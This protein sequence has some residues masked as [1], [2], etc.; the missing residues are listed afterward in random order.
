MN[1]TEIWIG[2][3]IPL[4]VGPLFIYLKSLYDN[5]SKNNRDNKLLVYENQY[6]KLSN[7]LT[8]FY[9]PVYIKLLCIYQ[10]NYNV[11]I[12]NKYEYISDSDSDIE[13]DNYELQNCR[14]CNNK[15]PKNTIK[16]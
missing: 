16:I 10:L 6:T 11:P 2:I 4:L 9:W 7:L 5:Y 1:T 12:K 3:I 14:I 13:Y 15:I 8:H